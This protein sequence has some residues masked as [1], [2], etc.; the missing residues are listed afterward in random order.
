MKSISALFVMG[1]LLCSSTSIFPI[2]LSSVMSYSEPGFRPTNVLFNVWYTPLI[3][4]ACLGAASLCASRNGFHARQKIKID[5]SQTFYHQELTVDKEQL[6]N[7]WQQQQNEFDA[8]KEAELNKKEARKVEKFYWKRG[9]IEFIYKPSKYSN[10]DTADRFNKICKWLASN[11]A[12]KDK[13]SSQE[14]LY[15]CLL[16]ML[17]IY[18]VAAY[19][20][21]AA[22]FSKMIRGN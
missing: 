16:T 3:G 15:E 13:D 8:H 4:S 11:Q 5:K 20:P 21:T 19:K 22:G 2:K 14:R 12:Y 1:C 9:N 18:K 17:S 7:Y 6:C 10:N